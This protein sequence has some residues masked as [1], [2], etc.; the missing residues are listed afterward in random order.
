MESVIIAVIVEAVMVIAVAVVNCIHSL[1]NFLFFTTAG[2]STARFA[3]R[4]SESPK[5]PFANPE[6][7]FVVLLWCYCTFI[8]V[9]LW[10]YCRFM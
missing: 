3:R 4:R 6:S 8:V 7:G 1:I 10:C 5:P 2:L 9:L